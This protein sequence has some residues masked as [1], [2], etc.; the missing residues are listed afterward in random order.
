MCALQLKDVVLLPRYTTRRMNIYMRL[1]VT[2]LYKGKIINEYKCNICKK[3]F[4]EINDFIEH[5]T[6]EG[7]ILSLI[8]ED[9]DKYTQL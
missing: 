1:K 7:C 9:K 6:E 8:E 3:E 4:E 5:A 2:R